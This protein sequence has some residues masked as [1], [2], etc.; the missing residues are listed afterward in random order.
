M[1]DED[2]LSLI[3]KFLLNTTGSTD[4]DAVPTLNTLQFQW[5]TDEV[6]CTRQFCTAVMAVAKL[7]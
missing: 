6:N 7:N 4:T 1:K 2:K 3:S 5:F